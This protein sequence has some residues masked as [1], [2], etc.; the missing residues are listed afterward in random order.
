MSLTANEMKSVINSAVIELGKVMAS[1]K[2]EDIQ[3]MKVNFSEQKK[4]IEHIKNDISEMRDDIKKFIE[5]VS[6]SDKRVIS[7]ETKFETHK[8]DPSHKSSY[9]LAIMTLIS[10]TFTALAGI[11]AFIISKYLGII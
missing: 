6:N 7:L 11:G 2:C 1:R 8:N 10:G 9:Y 5:E 4:D 3:N